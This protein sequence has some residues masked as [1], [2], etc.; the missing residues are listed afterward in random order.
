M[1][2][3]DVA[4]QRG[5]L[6]AAEFVVVLVEDVPPHHYLVL[7][8]VVEKSGSLCEAVS[9]RDFLVGNGSCTLSLLAQID[10]PV[11]IRCDLGDHSACDD[12]SG[13][14]FNFLFRNC[15]TDIV[16]SGKIS[17]CHNSELRIKN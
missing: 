5:I 15:T 11:T 2:C 4:S 9:L 13:R 17:F 7:R 1:P 8:Q 14:E 10:P 12:F 3:N 6:L 16:Q